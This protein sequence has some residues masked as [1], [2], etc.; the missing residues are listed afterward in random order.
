MEESSWKGQLEAL[1]SF[2]RTQRQLANMSL[3][4]MAGLSDISNAYLS[5]IERGLHQPSVRVLRSLAEALNL[6]AET[7][8]AQAGLLED[9]EG[10]GENDLLPPGP[11]R[12]AAAILADPSLTSEQKEALL[13]VHRSFSTGTGGTQ[14]T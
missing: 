12:T 7:L 5:Q 14:P 4:Q 11:A 8:L 3:R 2:I 10:G 9:D 6:S 13:S 1:G